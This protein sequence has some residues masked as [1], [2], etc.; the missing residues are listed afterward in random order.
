MSFRLP[1]RSGRAAQAVRTRVRGPASPEPPTKD[2]PGSSGEKEVVEPPV[3]EEEEDDRLRNEEDEKAEQRVK[4]RGVKADTEKTPE[5]KKKKYTVRVEKGFNVEEIMDRI[6]EGHNHLMNLKDVLASAPKLREELKARLCRKMVV[7]VRLGA[8][9]PK[10]A[11]WSETGTKMDWK[12]VA[13]GCFDVVVKGKACTAMVDTGVEMNIIKEEDA[14]PLGMEIDRSDNGIFVGANSQSIF[15]GIASKVVL[16]IGKSTCESSCAQDKIVSG[17]IKQE[18]MIKNLKKEFEEGGLV[19][20]VPDH[21]VVMT[22]PFII[23][24]DARPTALGGVLIQKDLNGE[25]RPLRFESRTLNTAERNYSQFKRKTLAVLHC[26]RIF[27]NYL[28]GSR[29]VLRVDPTGLVGSLKN[30]A[31]SDPTIAR[32]LTYIWIFDFEL[33]RI[34]GNKNRADGLNRVDWS[35]NSEGVIEDTP[36]VDGFLDD[37]EDVKL[38]INSWSLA[39]GNYITP[40]RPVWLTPPGYACLPNLVLKPYVEEDSWGLPDVQWM[41]D[42]ALADKHKLGEDLITMED[43]AR[44][45]EDHERSIGGVYLLA[46]ALLQEE[47][48][49]SARKDQERSEN[50]I[51]ERDGDDFEEGKIKEVFRAEEYDGVYLELRILL[52]C[53]MR[54]KDVSEKVLKMKPNFLVR[55]G[56]LFMKS[57]GRNPR[58]VVC[59]ITRQIDVMVALHDGTTGGQRSTDTTHAIFPIE[60]FLKTWRRHDLESELTFEELLDLRARQIG[61]IEDKIEGAT[62]KVAYNRAQDKFRWDKMTRVRKEPFEVGDTVL[63]YD[64]SLEKQWSRKLDKRWLGPYKVAKVGEHGAYQIEEMDGTAWRDWVSGSRL[65]KFVARDEDQ[66]ARQKELDRQERVTGEQEIRAEVRRKNLEELHRKVEQGKRPVDLKDR[67][68]KSVS[69]QQEED[70]P[71]LSEAWENFDR[72]MGAARRPEGPQQEM[73][74]KLVFTDL[75]ILKGVMNEGF[76]AARASDQE[77]GERL[78]KVAQKAYS[79]GVEWEQEVKELKKNQERQDRELDAMKVELE[80]AQQASFQAKE[81]KWEK[82]IK[83]PE[84]KLEQKAPTTLVDW[85]EVQGFEMKRSTAE[86]AFIS[87]KE[88]EKGDLQGGENVPLLDKEMLQPQEMHMEGKTKSEEFDWRMPSTVTLQQVRR[89]QDVTQQAEVVRDEGPLPIDRM[90][91]EGQMIQRSKVETEQGIGQETCQDSTMP[92]G[93]PLVADLEEALGSW[94]TGSGSAVRASGSARQT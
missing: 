43:E 60:S 25:E 27:R 2:I 70:P 39:V 8:I 38:H 50:V 16:E 77:I 92:Q 32:W 36:L 45:V 90:V 84:A 21:A 89:G 22:R 85:T 57:K 87:Q 6:L 67:N 81:G 30:Y 19:L 62:S 40:G 49:R 75:L 44:Q 26:L 14:L 28:F 42:L 72:L 34:P 58:R 93:T 88:E 9:I 48:A 12:S 37:E 68:E 80:K 15:V 83:E 59:D 55:D 17:E 54:E 74:V 47:V 71:L 29:F 7:C 4:K 35:K 76:A 94:A 41:M 20:G 61:A 18:S 56:H 24:T 53:E 79:Q 46:N 86:E 31:P 13:C 11:E 64:S 78:T 10:E 63:L 1:S 5:Q 91:A 69:S 3:N 66:A 82:R 65:R 52:S 23:E 73:G 33:E 51:H